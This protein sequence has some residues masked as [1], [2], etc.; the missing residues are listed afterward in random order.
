MHHSPTSNVTVLLLFDDTEDDKTWWKVKLWVF[1]E[2][3]FRNLETR[4]AATLKP[5]NE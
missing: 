5:N 2:I 3:Q 1:E 4:P